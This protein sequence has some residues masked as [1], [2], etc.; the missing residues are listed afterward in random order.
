MTEFESWDHFI[1]EVT[2]HKSLLQIIR[3]EVCYKALF[4]S[5]L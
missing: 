3:W 1:S 4:N 5:R 2:K